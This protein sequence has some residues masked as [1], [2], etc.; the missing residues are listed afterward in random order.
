MAKPVLSPNP[1]NSY[2]TLMS[3]NIGDQKQ[4]PVA[5]FQMTGD[6]QSDHR[7]PVKKWAELLPL[8]CFTLLHC[9][10]LVLGSTISVSIVDVFTSL[11]VGMLHYWRTTRPNVVA[12]VAEGFE[13]TPSLPNCAYGSS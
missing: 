4:M 9:S 10:E 11:I 12:T 1:S 6:W 7:L 2:V 13:Q 3:P 8:S 5:L